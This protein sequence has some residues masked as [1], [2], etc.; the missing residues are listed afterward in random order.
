MAAV[1][2]HYLERVAG[3]EGARRGEREKESGGR[4]RDEQPQ[5]HR[6]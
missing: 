2:G 1:G 5:R 4:G 6:L 3:E